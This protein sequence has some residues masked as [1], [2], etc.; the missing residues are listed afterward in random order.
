MTRS[1]HEAGPVVVADLPITAVVPYAPHPPAYTPA[2]TEDRWIANRSGRVVWELLPSR[3]RI[4]SRSSS[5]T[6][7]EG[8]RA[9]DRQGSIQ[10]SAL[11]GLFVDLYA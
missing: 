5:R 1:D 7:P 9:Y 11:K 2:H 3:G 4:D 10:T 8:I 6:V